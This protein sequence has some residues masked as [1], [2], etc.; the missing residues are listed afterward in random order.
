MPSAPT[1]AAPARNLTPNLRERFDA[2]RNLGPFLRQ[3]WQT[4][5]T[6]TLRAWA[7]AWCARS[8]PW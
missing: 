6:L 7:C 5:R 4:S 3:I 2:M 1:H 8:S